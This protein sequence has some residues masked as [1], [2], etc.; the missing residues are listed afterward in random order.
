MKCRVLL[1]IAACSAI[2]MAALPA[3]GASRVHTTRMYVFEAGHQLQNQHQ[4]PT[5]KTHRLGLRRSSETVPPPMILPGA[6]SVPLPD[7]AAAIH[8]DEPLWYHVELCSRTPRAPP[9][10][11]LS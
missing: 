5:R 10:D 7:V 1:L 11:Q 8:H 3:T 6:A 2:C 4:H 9:S